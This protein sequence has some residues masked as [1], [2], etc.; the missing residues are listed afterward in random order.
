MEDVRTANAQQAA[1]LLDVEL[2][3]LL[4]LLMR[5]ERSAS[6]VAQLLEVSVQRAHYLLGKLTRAGVAVVVR[7]DARAGRAVKQYRMP[8]R[9]FIPYE[10]T[11]AETL[12][13]FASAQVL[14]RVERLVSHSARLLREHSPHWGFWLEGGTENASLLIGDEHSP[15]HE[16]FFGDEPFLMSLGSMHLSRERAGELKRRLMDVLDDF[17]TESTPGTSEYTVALMLVRG[18][19]D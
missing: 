13:A 12:E 4:T 2:R 5:G 8:E 17:G 7:E 11:G 1:L 10:V 9:W 14:P 16:L 15:A 6:Q 18:G 3:A 19:I